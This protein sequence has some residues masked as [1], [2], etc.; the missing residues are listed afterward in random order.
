MIEGEGGHVD[1]A[2]LD[3]Q[4]ALV[5]RELSARFGRVSVE[6]LLSGEGIMNIYG[7]LA[8]EYAGSKDYQTPAQVPEAALNASN[9]LAV[10][11]LELFCRVLGA[12]AGNLALTVG[13]RGGVYIA[14]GIVP[15]FVEVLRR[16]GFRERFESKG[17]FRGYLAEIP[18]RVVVKQDL[19]LSGAMMKLRRAR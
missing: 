4:E 19:G 5:F 15:R 18:V 8:V 17:R 1:F 2:P 14:G 3:A 12:V 10:E 6:R 13:A 9:P 11:T 16:S 7:A